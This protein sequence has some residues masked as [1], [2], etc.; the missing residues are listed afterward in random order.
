MRAARPVKATT[1]L[2]REIVKPPQPL[3][4]SDKASF[5][6]QIPAAALLSLLIFSQRRGVCPAETSWSPVGIGPLAR[7]P[8]LR[9]PS[10]IISR[11]AADTLQLGARCSPLHRGHHD[12]VVELSSCLA[13]FES[14]PS[15]SVPSNG[16]RAPPQ[17]RH[18]DLEMF[19]V[20][21]WE[22]R[23]IVRPVLG[24]QDAAHRRTMTVGKKRNR[25]ERIAQRSPETSYR[26]KSS[27]ALA[28][29]TFKRSH[30]STGRLSENAG[31]VS[32]A[33]SG[34]ETWED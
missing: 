9:P 24:R 1:T 7:L 8:L 3:G 34:T 4:R 30:L 31:T 16:G 28:M 10:S 12:H 22:P 32:T 14:P 15:P 2:G 17:N 11:L 33:L 29:A 13:Q 21:P 26:P 6:H 20:C 23:A 27:K 5:S 25:Y 18:E 19:Q